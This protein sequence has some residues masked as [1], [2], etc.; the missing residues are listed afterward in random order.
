MCL[1]EPAPR[2]TAG[3]MWE[4]AGPVLSP[5]LRGGRPGPHLVV[6][7][8]HVSGEKGCRPL[9]GVAWGDSS[10]QLLQRPLVMG[11]ELVGQ[12]QVQLL[13]AG[14][15]AAVCASGG[16]RAVSMDLRTGHLPPP[17]LPPLGG[18]FLLRR[19]LGFP[20]CPASL[21]AGCGWMPRS[22]GG[23]RR[24]TEAQNY[25]LRGSGALG[26]LISKCLMKCTVPSPLSLRVCMDSAP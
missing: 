16:C 13:G 9:A 26:E 23:G 21:A 12:R 10:G 1:G 8:A 24:E 2:C 4:G 6:H 7:E 11:V 20:W 5:G 18:C 3:S 19:G 25:G 22:F 17:A 14:L 15:H